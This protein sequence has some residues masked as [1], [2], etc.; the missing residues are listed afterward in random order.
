[1]K[2]IINSNFR[3][4]PAHHCHRETTKQQLVKGDGHPATL[5]RHGNHKHKIIAHMQSKPTWSCSWT[6]GGWEPP[7]R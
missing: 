7:P 3:I 4:Q 1:M 5:G 2:L 6:N